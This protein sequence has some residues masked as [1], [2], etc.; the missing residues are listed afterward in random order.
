LQYWDV[1]GGGT[2][3]ADHAATRKQNQQYTTGMKEGSARF[4]PNDRPAEK[5]F[6]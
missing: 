2:I 5:I 1:G 3:T 4:A 6:P